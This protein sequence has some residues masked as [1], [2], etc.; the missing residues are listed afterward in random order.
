M[1]HIFAAICLFCSVFSTHTVEAKSLKDKVGDWI[2][3]APWIGL[4]ADKV[5]YGPITIKD[6]NI[7]DAGKL[8]FVK[9]GELITGE[10]K[11]KIDAEKLDSWYLHHIIVGLKNQDAQCCITHSFGM[12]DESGKASFAFHAPLEKGL[13][14]LRFD[15]QEAIFCA[16]AIN[17]WHY[18]QPSNNATIGIV[19]VE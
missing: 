11:Y 10:L 17:E 14:E 13:Y 6:V 12:W 3:S 8:L 1:K 19:I 7:G 5:T 16:T 2:K 15:Y 9:P 4:I 18:D